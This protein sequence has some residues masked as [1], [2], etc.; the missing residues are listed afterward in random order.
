M[1]VLI[2]EFYLLRKI[3]ECIMYYHI[4]RDFDN[5]YNDWQDY[6]REA[7]YQFVGYASEL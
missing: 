5:I 7:I 4:N 3:M 6:N 2:G 1:G